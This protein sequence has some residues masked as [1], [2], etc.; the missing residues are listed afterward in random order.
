M[1]PFTFE[2]YNFVSLLHY[3]LVLIGQA[4]SRDKTQNIDKPFTFPLQSLI[5]SKHERNIF[6]F[7]L[8]YHMIDC[9]QWDHRGFFVK[10]YVP[11]Q[12]LPSKGITWSLIFTII[13]FSLV[14]L[15]HAILLKTLISCSPAPAQSCIQNKH[16]R[17]KFSS[18]LLHHVIK[19]NQYDVRELIKMTW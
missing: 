16:E 17:N 13:L 8:F 9:N 14:K 6:S 12:Q 3:H 18:K 11:M 15:D 7:T 19:C 2:R 1:Q 4:W 5:Q 10:I